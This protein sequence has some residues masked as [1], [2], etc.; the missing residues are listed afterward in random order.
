[1]MP[2]LSDLKFP[3]GCETLPE[4]FW[5]AVDVW[6]KKPHVVNKRLCGVKET[7]SEDVGREALD[8]L[9]QDHPGL[10]QDVYSFL[11]SQASPARTHEEDKP[12]SSS[13]RTIIPKVNCYGT[14]L[15]K[16]LVLK[17]KSL[18]ESLNQTKQ[19]QTRP[20]FLKLSFCVQDFARQQVSFLPF[21]EDSGGQ[22]SLKRGNIHQI[23]LISPDCE[24][25]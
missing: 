4:G 5:S 22:V 19:D 11:S 12:W 2:K 20:V 7:E 16:E 6:I 24:E 21:E 17:G 1:M 14:K 8:L 13:V 15:Q 10:S 18:K 25:W 3:A 9:L 23:Q